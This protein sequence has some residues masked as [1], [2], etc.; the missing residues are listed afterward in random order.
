MFHV[1]YSWS[2]Q[3]KVKVLLTSGGDVH[4]VICVGSIHN[5]YFYLTPSGNEQAEK[6]L[7]LFSSPATPLI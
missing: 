1:F 2:S 5:K 6:T 3:E 7:F 4:D